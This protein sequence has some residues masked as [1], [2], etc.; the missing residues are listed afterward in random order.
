MTQKKTVRRYEK[1]VETEIEK[2]DEEIKEIT[3]AKSEH[4]DGFKREQKQLEEL[5]EHFRKVDA[6]KY[7]INAEEG[8]ADARKAKQK[9]ERDR[10]AQA[11]SQVQAFWRGI[12]QRELYQV[13]KKSKKSK[14]GKKNK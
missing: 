3:T 2:Y 8:I 13:M 14:K 4:S 10:K 5:R 9:Y 1:N 11:S 6:E 7:C 12:L